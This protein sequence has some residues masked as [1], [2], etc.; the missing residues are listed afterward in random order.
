ME[1]ITNN[2]MTHIRVPELSPEELKLPYAK[3]YTDYLEKKFS[4]LYGLDG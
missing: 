3:Y 4:A 2:C 1:L